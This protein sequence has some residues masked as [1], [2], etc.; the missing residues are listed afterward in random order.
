[1]LQIRVLAASKGHGAEWTGLE[2]FY[3]TGGARYLLLLLLQTLEGRDLTVSLLAACL[4]VG[5]GIW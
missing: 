2:Q 1:M 3:E 4:R 5:E